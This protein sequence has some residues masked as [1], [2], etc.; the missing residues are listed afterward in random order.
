MSA[1]WSLPKMKRI[2]SKNS[3]SNAGSRAPLLARFHGGD[4]R[5]RRLQGGRATGGAPAAAGGEVQVRYR[6]H[7]RGRAGP[8][9][10]LVPTPVRPQADAVLRIVGRDSVRAGIP[11]GY[12]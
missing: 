11:R 4:R 1:Y 6:A 5:R 3:S 8:A 9:V 10:G 7:S 2:I 12:R